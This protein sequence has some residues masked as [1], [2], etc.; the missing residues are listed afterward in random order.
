MASETHAL[1][2]LGKLEKLWK[3]G[4]YVDCTIQATD[5]EIKCHQI[6]LTCVT[7]PIG[8]MKESFNDKTSIIHVNAS[9][10]GVSQ[11]LSL[12]YITSGAT[13]D[14]YNKELVKTAKLF[15]MDISPTPKLSHLV[16]SPSPNVAIMEKFCKQRNSSLVEQLSNL[17]KSKSLSD[18]TLIVDK[19]KFCCHKVLLVSFSPYFNAMFSSELRE[20]NQAEIDIFSVDK[21]TFKLILD[22]IYTGENITTLTNF[23]QI[24]S[25]SSYLQIPLLQS[26][27]ERFIARHIDVDNCVDVAKLGDVF[28]SEYIVSKTASYICRHFHEISATKAFFT[29]TKCILIRIL[30]NNQINTE[31]EY[32]VLQAVLS[33]LTHQ[34]NEVD[35][36][37]LIKN[38]KLSF[39]VESELLEMLHNPQIRKRNDCVEYIN[40]VM[41]NKNRETENNRTFNTE[42][43]MAVMWSSSYRPGLYL[44][45]YSFRS[46]LWYQLPSLPNHS[47][48]CS[49]GA[50]SNECDIYICG[51]TGNITSFHQFN[52]TASEWYSLGPMQLKYGRA[53]HGMVAKNDNLYIIGG[54]ADQIIIWPH[55]DRYNTKSKS[56][57]RIGS[58][59]IAV[60]NPTCAIYDDNI[61]IFGGNKS[62]G[63]YVSSIQQFDLSTNSCTVL[64]KLPIMCS[65]SGIAVN[66]DA[67][68]IVGPRGDVVLY[69]YGKDPVIVGSV[70][71][72]T[73][74]GFG[75]VFYNGKLIILGG[76]SERFES[77]EARAFDTV[78]KTSCLT[79]RN[80][81]IPAK[82]ES[83]QYYVCIHNIR[84]SM[85][86]A[87]KLYQ[88]S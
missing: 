56:Y 6:L 45:C 22:F 73:I 81:K 86:T 30:C 31:N 82:K 41:K 57:D 63:E 75:T 34:N 64:S 46:N 1:H 14:S 69:E 36:M 79:S 88:A 44:A 52:F 2:F 70:F 85:L 61:V 66:E 68:Y 39:L 78:K 55:I 67:V 74:F 62:F 40:D 28:G 71:K 8:L 58:L 13:S 77:V 20:M 54:S 17:Q 47:T 72:Q 18:I 21:S 76:R 15:G 60:M 12:L 84:K 53:D 37:D 59:S 50:C 51:G 19:Q 23:E 25:A 27:C 80:M 5:G 48:G 43:V 83:N 10:K 42:E 24:I 32:R 49:Y 35:I 4:Q 26:K 9:L 7:S 3:A 29:L 33:W 87:D 65:Y 38:I 16:K 11:F